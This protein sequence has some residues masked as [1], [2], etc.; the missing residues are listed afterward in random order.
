MSRRAREKDAAFEL[1]QFL[2]NDVAATRRFTEAGQ[3]VANVTVHATPE[4]QADAFARAFAQQVEHTVPLSNRPHMRRVWTPVKD[5]LSAAIVRGEPPA[6][7]L[8]RAA[9]SVR[10]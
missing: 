9:R 3:L 5:A 1:A 7:A 10:P 4:F 2:T 6:A 8:E